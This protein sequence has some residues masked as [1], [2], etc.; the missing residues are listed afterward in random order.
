M[1]DKFNLYKRLKKDDGVFCALPF[2][3]M[4]IH[5]SQPIRPCCTYSDPK[6]DMLNTEKNVVR[7]LQEDWNNDYY[8]KIRKEIINGKSLKGCQ[9]CYRNEN[10]GDRSDRTSFNTRF[11][12]ILKENPELQDTYVDVEHGNSFK[13]PWD[14][15]LRPGNLCN[16]QCRMCGPGSSSQLNKEYK[17]LGLVTFDEELQTEWFTEENFE[18][19]LRNID[20]GKKIKFLGGEPTLMTG[21]SDILDMLIEQNKT[22]IRIHFT[23]NLTNVNRNFLDRIR[24][25]NNISISISMDGVGPTLEYIRYP[26]KWEQLSNNVK[27]YLDIPGVRSMDVSFTIQAYNITNILD[28]CKWIEEFNEKYDAAVELRP[29]ILTW[30]I[31]LSFKNLPKEFRDKYLNEIL[32]YSYKKDEHGKSKL[33]HL[34]KI[35]YM[36]VINKELDPYDFIYNTALFDISRNQ[37]I[38]DY[39][40]ELW[41]VIKDDYI[42]IKKDILE[43]TLTKK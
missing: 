39:I 27:T 24:K 21:V 32:N 15:D 9:E 43:K 33:Y 41:D 22:D 11:L 35:K 14:L 25:F 29:K 7:N 26:I 6:D 1:D 31:H 30:P 5:N 18:F 34:K 36:S 19:L 13:T 10:N 17:K 2:L 12:N 4:L 8:K 23:S 28:T 37:C 16:L 20:K 42:V 40:P 3:H 38:G